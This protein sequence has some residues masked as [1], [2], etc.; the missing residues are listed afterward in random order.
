MWCSQPHTAGFSYPE[1]RRD[2]PDEA[3]QPTWV[4]P[5]AVLIP[6]HPRMREMRGGQTHVTCMGAN[7]F[8]RKGFLSLWRTLHR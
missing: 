4:C 3:R 2:W 8:H 7:L 6:A 5:G 1:R